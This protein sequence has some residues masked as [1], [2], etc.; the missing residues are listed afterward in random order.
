MA[1]DHQSPKINSQLVVTVNIVRPVARYQQKNS[2]TSLSFFI[3]ACVC[4]TV[5]L[6]I[7]RLKWLLSPRGKHPSSNIEQEDEELIEEIG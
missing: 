7:S 5:G 1:I 2:N 4:S 6:H 3:Y